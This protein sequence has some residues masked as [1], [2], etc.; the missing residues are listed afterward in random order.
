M[1]PSDRDLAERACEKLVKQFAVFN[2][3]D[4][5][6]RVADLFTEDGSFARPLDPINPTIGRSA[7]L[8]MLQSRPPRLSR[9]YMTNILVDVVSDTEATGISFVTFLTTTEVDAPR[10]V[11]CEPK[12]YMGEY[13]DTFV[14]TVEGWKIKSRKGNLTMIFEPG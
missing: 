4:Q 3:T 9:H 1:K 8:S 12:M 7:I 14:F 10:P 5:L 11:V 2:D 13:H 6:E